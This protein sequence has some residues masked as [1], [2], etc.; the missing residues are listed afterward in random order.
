[1]ERGL[2][3]L[4]LLAAFIGLAWMGSREYQKLEAYKT[5]A[6]AFDNSKYDI[7]AVLG[8]KDKIITWGKPTTKGPINLQSFSLEEV[9]QIR[10]LVKGQAVDLDNLPSRGSSELEF[11][12]KTTDIPIKIPFTEIE[13]GAKWARYLQQHDH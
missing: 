1:M 5:W 3:W 13:L 8:L 9:Q 6:V 2:L 4:P 12:L 10:L 11:S 7:Y